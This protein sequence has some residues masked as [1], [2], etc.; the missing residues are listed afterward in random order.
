MIE[1]TRINVGN[2][3]YV[4]EMDY[5]VANHKEDF[6]R[7]VGLKGPAGYE[8]KADDWIND[9]IRELELINIKEGEYMFTV[10]L[11]KSIKLYSVAGISG[12]IVGASLLIGFVIYINR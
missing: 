6:D 3:S 10:D 4:S 7:L 11:N 12:Y 9:E 8:W 1:N 2:A 5:I